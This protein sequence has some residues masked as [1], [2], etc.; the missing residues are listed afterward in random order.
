MRLN[1]DMEILVLEAPKLWLRRDRSPKQIMAVLDSPQGQPLGKIRE[2]KGGWFAPRTLEVCELE[3]ESLVF[4]LQRRLWSG[5]VLTD[6][7]GQRVGR[8]SGRQGQALEDG[9]G[10]PLAGVQDTGSDSLIVA[11]DGRQLGTLQPGADGVEVTFA[12]EVAGEPFVKMLVLATA[13]V[14][15]W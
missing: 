12:A 8:L 3:D 4:Q 15:A 5:W 2:V 7:E 6:A 11:V 1:L 13:I 10:R 14:R 9:A